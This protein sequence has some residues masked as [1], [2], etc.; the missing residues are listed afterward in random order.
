MQNSQK[1]Q[2]FKENEFFYLGHFFC[3]TGHLS[4]DVIQHVESFLQCRWALSEFGVSLEDTFCFAS[5]GE[6]Y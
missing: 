5:K 6:C 1:I 2:I 3:P 4:S